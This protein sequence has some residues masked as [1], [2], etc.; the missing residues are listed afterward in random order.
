MAAAM[1]LMP[2]IDAIAKLLSATISPL[3]VT[4]GRFF[5]Q[6]LL[7]APLVIIFSGWRGLWP[8]RVL[9][10]ALRGLLI[11]L[12]SLFFFTAVKFMPLADT[13][14]IFFVEPMILTVLSAVVLKEHVGWPRRI[15]VIVGFI[16]AL[17]VIRP[18]FASVGPV[19]L[20]PVGA[21][22]SFAFYLILTRR[23]TRY[24]GAL[25]M[26]FA[27]GVSGMVLLSLCLAIGHWLAIPAI[28]PSLATPQV[29]GLLI[30]IGLV[31]TL[32]H[33]MVVAAFQRL[34]ASMLAGFQYLE[35]VSG[36]LL[37][38]WIFGDFPDPITWLGVAIIIASG[39][40]IYWREAR[41]SG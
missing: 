3:Q 40:F 5:F 13:L 21:A 26:Q 2:G 34:P 35:I 9:G 29:W 36:T 20:L 32:G 22:F 8:N 14:A 15:A 6:V 11:A 41:I 23:L 25:T 18:S 1:L 4:W 30:V 28:A 38:L 37:G 12:A 10:N 7:M 27:A 17:V 24:D 31:A 16:G 33:L 39:L 19:A